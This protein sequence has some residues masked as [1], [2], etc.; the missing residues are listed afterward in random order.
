MLDLDGKKTSVLDENHVSELRKMSFFTYEKIA[1]HD[2]IPLSRIKLDVFATRVVIHFPK[3]VP[4]I[5]FLR[6]A[7]PSRNRTCKSVSQP[8]AHLPAKLPANLPADLPVRLPACPPY[9]PVHLPA[10]LPA[11]LPVNLPVHLLDH[12]HADLMPTCLLTCLPT[13][14]PNY[15][16]T[17]PPTYLPTCLPQHA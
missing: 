12:V 13:C 8:T 14:L 16:P 3:E 15:L 2:R 10:H 9:L 11:N 17:Y 5:S 7:C 6:G 4:K 1:D